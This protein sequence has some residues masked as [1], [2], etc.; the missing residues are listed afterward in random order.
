MLKI[1]FGSII[2][3]FIAGCVSW[4]GFVL[5]SNMTPLPPAEPTSPPSTSAPAAV[6]IDHG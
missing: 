5:G 1:V 6:V 4:I 2:V 3:V